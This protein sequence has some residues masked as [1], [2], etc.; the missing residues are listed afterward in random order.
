MRVKD[1]KLNTEYRYKNEIVKMV[2]RIKNTYKE[3]WR[4]GFGTKYQ[5]IK[6]TNEMTFML[7]NGV[8]C[9]AKEIS[10]LVN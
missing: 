2:K 9:Y 3:N 8:E 10:A 7:S 6:H 4:Y 1:V 5:I